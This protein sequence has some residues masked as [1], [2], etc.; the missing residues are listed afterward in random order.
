[1]VPLLPLPA[2]VFTVPVVRTI[3]SATLRWFGI[4][5]LPVAEPNSVNH[6]ALDPGR[7][8]WKRAHINLPAPRIL[9]NRLTVSTSSRRKGKAQEGK[10]SKSSNFH[11]RRSP[12]L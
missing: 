3:I 8:V 11:H 5:D 2:T 4:E 12:W 10:S 1:M 6:P 9:S 7:L